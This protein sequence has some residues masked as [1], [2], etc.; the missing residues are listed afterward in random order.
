MI[1][2]LAPKITDLIHFISIA[3]LKVIGDGI[4][5]PV[6]QYKGYKKK[7]FFGVIN[8]F[9][10]FLALSAPGRLTPPTPS[11]TSRGRGRGLGYT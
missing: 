3:Y 6:Y 7:V 11:P 4:Y 2:T 8:I 9:L 1:S 10:S 5:T